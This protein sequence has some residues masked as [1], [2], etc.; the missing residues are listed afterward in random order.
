[1]PASHC[2]PI[3][4]R[5]SWTLLFLPRALLCGLLAA[6]CGP[7]AAAPEWSETSSGSSSGPVTTVGDT[8]TS[9]T[10]GV[11]PTST[12]TGDQPCVSAGCGTEAS[13]SSTTCMSPGCDS[14]GET[15]TSVSCDPFAQDC[16]EG[17]KCA[18]VMPK[19]GSWSETRCVP[20]NGDGQPGDDC[21]AESVADGLDDCAK[22]VMCWDVDVNGHGECVEQ[23]SGS[24]G[25]PFCSTM[26][27]CTFSADGAL[28]LCLPVCS[29]LLQDC[30]EG[31]ACYPASDNF[32]CAPDVSGEEGQAND[33]CEF[34]NVCDPG[35]MCADAG[36]VGA[37]CPQGSPACCTPFCDLSKPAACPNPDQ[38]C[39]PFFDPMSIP[40]T[41]PDAAKIGV[42]GLPF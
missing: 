10:S 7:K 24:A 5:L 3:P 20:V 14:D 30:E 23:C 4:R 26:G 34:I 36:F 6:G 21:V 40:I 28:N 2:S 9:S 12:T 39:V 25:A 1:M 35:L 31:N 41:P 19:G 32:S 11:Q 16:P 42:C 13:S 37:G 15:G 29:P 18:P 22:G 38:Q 27:G 8:S 17:Q 33:P